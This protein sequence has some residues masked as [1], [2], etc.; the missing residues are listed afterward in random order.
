[1]IN[2]VI[3]MT[4]GA[5]DL[6]VVAMAGQDHVLWAGGPIIAVY[7]VG[8]ILTGA[9]YG[10]TDWQGQAS[11]RHALFALAFTVAFAPLA[12]APSA[13]WLAAAALVAGA[14]CAPI[15]ISG[16]ALVELCVPGPSVT[17]A[18]AWSTSAVLVG[19]AAGSWMAGRVI[20]RGDAHA[21]LLLTACC[22]LAVPAA[23]ALLGPRRIFNLNRRVS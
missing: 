9:A 3:G 4:F 16:N 6:S 13:A 23:C 19:A 1:M 8:S 17:E 22:A 14:A 21:G 7:S 2:A 20:A 11:R 15:L 18:L 10:R 12:L 5:N